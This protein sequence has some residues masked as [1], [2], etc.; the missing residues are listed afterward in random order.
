MP[1]PNAP[2]VIPRHPTR[3]RFKCFAVACEF[4]HHATN[5]GIQPS[6]IAGPGM[7]FPCCGKSR[8]DATHLILFPRLRPRRQPSRPLV[9]AIHAVNAGNFL[10][11]HIETSS[12]TLAPS[13]H[14]AARILHRQA[15]ALAMQALHVKH[16]RALEARRGH[17]QLNSLDEFAQSPQQPVQRTR[18]VH[19]RARR[20]SYHA[21]CHPCGTTPPCV[22]S[23]LIPRSNF[24]NVAPQTP[25]PLA[26]RAAPLHRA[27]RAAIPEIRARCTNSVPVLR[28]R[29]CEFLPTARPSQLLKWRRHR[30]LQLLVKLFLPARKGFPQEKRSSCGFLCA[31]AC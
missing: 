5:R 23:L 4:V 19:A 21:I 16:L 12:K 20:G 30:D 13:G 22:T 8:N 17:R 28:P 11:P 29:D 2:H 26:I 24:I 31:N 7:P 18:I 10:L 3:L 15:F 6:S 1:F 25:S 27:S 9:R 14:I